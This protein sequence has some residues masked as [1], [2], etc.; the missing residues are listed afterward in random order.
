[1]VSLIQAKEAEAAALADEA[2]S[3]E[4][5]ESMWLDRVSERKKDWQAAERA[6]ACAQWHVLQVESLLLKSAPQ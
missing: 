1:M 2:A 5:D 6:T 4:S 3:L